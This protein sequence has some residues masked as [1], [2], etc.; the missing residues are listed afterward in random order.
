MSVVDR[1]HDSSGSDDGDGGADDD[2]GDYDDNDISVIL[3]SNEELIRVVPEGDD[4]IGLY[5]H[6]IDA[7]SAFRSDSSDL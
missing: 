1:K 7:D 5:E 4:P 2:Y 6:E 3:P